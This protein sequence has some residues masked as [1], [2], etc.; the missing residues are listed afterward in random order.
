LAS[1]AHRFQIG[2]ELNRQC[3]GWYRFAA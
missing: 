2:F 3:R 1:R